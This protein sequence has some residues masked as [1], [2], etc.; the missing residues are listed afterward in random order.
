MLISFGPVW[1]VFAAHL[2]CVPTLCQWGYMSFLYFVRKTLSYQDDWCEFC[3]GG[4]SPTE[5]SNQDM[6]S[7]WSLS[8]VRAHYAILQCLC[9]FMSFQSLVHVQSRM[10]YEII[11]YV[12]KF[13]F[14]LVLIIETIK[15]KRSWCDL[16]LIQFW[17]SRI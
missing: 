10:C 17:I 14:L 8:L 3:C 1:L 11:M 12:T 6:F 7:S 5:T 15:K 9:V 2:N 4:F 13:Y 16:K